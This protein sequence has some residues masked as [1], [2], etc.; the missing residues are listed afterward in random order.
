MALLLDKVRVI[1]LT[2]VVAGPLASYQLVMLGAEVIKIE[3]PASGGDVSRTVPPFQEG[4]DSLFFETFNRGKRSISLDLR[5]PRGRE[6]LLD[7]VGNVWEWCSDWYDKAYYSVSPKENPKGPT[8]GRFNTFRG[9]AWDQ[10]ARNNRVTYRNP[11]APMSRTHN[12]G[13]RVVCDL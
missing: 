11:L 4:E 3:D 6:G 1:D 13:F 2:N 12:K 5:H 9:G 8:T 10:G 7:L